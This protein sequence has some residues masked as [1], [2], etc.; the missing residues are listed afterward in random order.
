MKRKLLLGMLFTTLGL[1]AQTTHHINWFM[2]VTTAQASMTIEEGDVV[3]WT[4]ADASPHTV[5]SVAGGAETFT[6]GTISGQGETFSHTFTVVGATSYQCNIHNM[7][8][9][10]ITVDTVA[11]IKESSKV[12][13]EYFPNPTTDIL[14]INAKDIIDS[15]EVYDVNGREIMNAK[16][17]N[18]T[19]KIYMAN[20]KAGT[21]FIKV[22]IGN[23]SENITV[24]KK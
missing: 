1:S 19:S 16:S 6:S 3:T 11:G 24:I 12:D 9:G 17:G 21:Y 13:F 8:K 22:K 2:G 20:Y 15:I 10:V 14:T 23:K 4:L 5:S 18:A 7:M